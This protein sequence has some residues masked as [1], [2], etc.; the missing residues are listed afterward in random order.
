MRALVTGGVGFI[1]RH[2]SHMLDPTWD[3][4]ALDILSPQVHADPDAARKDFPGEVIVGDVADESVWGSLT[5]PDLVI[6]LAAETG[7]AQSMYDVDH[8]MRV[9]VGGTR[10]AGFWSRQWQVPLI[11]MSSRAV[12]GEGRY[13]HPD[14]SVSFGLPSGTGAVPEPSRES[15]DHVPV[16]VYGNTKSLGEKALA[17]FAVDVPVTIVRP[18]NVVGRGQALHNPY[19]GVLAAFLARLREGKPILVY[20]D[21]HQTRDFVHVSDLARLVVWLTRRSDLTVR[22]TAETGEPLVLN[23]GTGYRTN[24]NELA[25]YAIA[26]SPA[27]RA[28][29]ELLDVHRAGDIEHAC[30][31]MTLNKELGTPVA[32]W[33]TAE[34]VADFISW[35]WDKPGADS[36][37]WD[38][39]LEELSRRGLTS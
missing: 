23:S 37:A 17:Q 1:G 14:G 18:Q 20:G 32:R 19:T 36:S 8:Y 7:T 9:N 12:Y 28:R 29:I 39:A 33:A 10:L 2:L 3:L 6:H 15:D 21:G 25:Q 5:P 22:H 13:R 38:G 24:L 4:A 27:S 35:S 30:A 31:D 26:G 11:S 16:S 34:A